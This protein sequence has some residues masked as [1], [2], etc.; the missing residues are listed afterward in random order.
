MS[1]SLPKDSL[2][3]R[4]AATAHFCT[5]AL[6]SLLDSRLGDTVFV[7]FGG[8]DGPIPP[9]TRIAAMTLATAYWAAMHAQLSQYTRLVG[10][11]PPIPCSGPSGERNCDNSINR[12]VDTRP[13]V[14]AQ[15][16]TISDAPF[17]VTSDGRGPYRRR[18]SNVGVVYIARIAVLN[19]ADFTFDSM[20]PRS[21]KVDL[22]RPVPGGNGVPLG[23]I[24]DS[25]GIEVSTQW[26][27]DSAYI[28]RS[29]L[30]IPIDSTVIAQQMEVGFHING[31]FHALQ[32]GPQ[33]WGHCFS[34]G[35]AVHGAG[36]S[37]GTIRRVS[38]TKWEATLVPGS[39][40][41]LFDISNSSPNAVDKGL[42]YVSMRFTIER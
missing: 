35:T 9:R 42:Y 6:A 34:D 20:P 7:R 4:L 24:S 39:I 14:G 10:R 28:T 8:P 32:M 29:L 25:R 12:C 33:P 36:T 19:L 11:V 16:F 23:V 5:E 18:S 31:T 3:A 38:E 15:T 2:L 30:D 13:G 41:R 1:A 26:G 37:R 22:S 17:S 21:V 27:R 40:G